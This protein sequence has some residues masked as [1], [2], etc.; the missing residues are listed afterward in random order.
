LDGVNAI[1]IERCDRVRISELAAA[2]AVRTAANADEAAAS[3]QSLGAAADTTPVHR[4]HQEDFCQA[5]ADFLATSIKAREVPVR[6]TS[7][8]SIASVRL[9]A[10]WTKSEAANRQRMKMLQPSST[11]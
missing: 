6:P 4:V 3:A 9:G 2:T 11:P 10:G 8:I 7:S 5:L 1:V